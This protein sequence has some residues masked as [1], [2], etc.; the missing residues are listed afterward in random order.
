[1]VGGGRIF[2][3][4]LA[5]GLTALYEPVRPLAAAI[6]ADKDNLSVVPLSQTLYAMAAVVLVS[7]AFLSLAAW[8][9][10]QPM[11]RYGIRT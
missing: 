10:K 5:D 9:V 3:P 8:M 6:I 4:N 11:K 1:M 2:A 7:A